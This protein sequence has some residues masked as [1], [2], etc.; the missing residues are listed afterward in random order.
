MPIRVERDPSISWVIID[1]EDKGN[2]LD[3]EHARE[4][5]RAIAEECQA[6]E[7]SVVALTGSGTRFFSTGVDLASVAEVRDEKDAWKLMY[8]G[9]GGICGALHECSKPVI[10][11]VNGHAIGIGFELLHA[12]DIA[13]AVKGAKFGT[14]AVKWGMVPPGTPTV[15]PIL[16]GYK[17][18]AYLVLTGDLIS[19]D[20]ARDRGI[21]NIV[22]EDHEEL[23][24]TVRE[25]AEKIAGNDQWAVRMAKELL[26]E[27]RSRANIQR[28]LMALVY[29]TAR[30]ETRERTKEFFK[31]KEKKHG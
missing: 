3:Y 9:L 20:E 31:K 29:S 2:S 12:V 23:R 16:L 13:V 25:I 30:K 14:P 6:T 28:G 11:A 22:V 8:E 18:A 26:R 27:A 21:V 19:A 24:K 17:T 15:G 10:A 4:L 5:A 1:R 7:T